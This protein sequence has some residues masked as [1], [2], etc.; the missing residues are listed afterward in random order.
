MISLSN[1]AEPAVHHRPDFHIVDNLDTW[2]IGA[3]HRGGQAD[4][5]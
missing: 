2:H 5:G 1:A 4:A 3:R